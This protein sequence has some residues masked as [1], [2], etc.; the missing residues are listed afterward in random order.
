MFR[1]FDNIFH[2]YLIR[3]FQKYERNC[4]FPVAF[5]GQS[6]AGQKCAARWAELAVLFYWLL[7]K[8]LW[9]F[10]FFHI[11]GIPLSSRHE[12]F[13]Q[14]L[15]RLF[16]LFHHFRNI[17]W[18]ASILL[19][20]HSFHSDYLW[21]HKCPSVGTEPTQTSFFFLSS[22]LVGMMLDTWLTRSSNPG[23]F[24]S[25]AV[26]LGVLFLCVILLLRRAIHDQPL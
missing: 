7:K 2:V 23:S 24:R 11:F 6:K 3:R 19:R 8:P 1:G 13:C 4:I 16:V 22:L 26:P 18:G 25:G 10:N 21:Y 20:S 14:M 9:E 5:W 15:E 12:I 17:T